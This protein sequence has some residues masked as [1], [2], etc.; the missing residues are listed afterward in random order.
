MIVTKQLHELEYHSKLC[1][2]GYQVWREA[3]FQRETAYFLMSYCV[4]DMDKNINQT[5]ILWSHH[6]LVEFCEDIFINSDTSLVNVMVLSPPWMNHS[7]TW[8]IETLNQIWEVESP[9]GSFE[10]LCYL[11]VGGRSYLSLNLDVEGSWDFKR[12]IFNVGDYMCVES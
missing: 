7:D 6:D 10:S 9:G 5:C 12:N 11:T 4:N 3:H 1:G 2:S 8:L